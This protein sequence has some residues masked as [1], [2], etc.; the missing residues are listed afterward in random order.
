MRGKNSPRVLA[1]L[2]SSRPGDERSAGGTALSM[3]RQRCVANSMVI[4]E[5][6]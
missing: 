3:S 2:E 6:G 5:Y 1:G 4:V